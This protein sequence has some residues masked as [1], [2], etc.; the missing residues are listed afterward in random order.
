MQDRDFLCRAARRSWPRAQTSAMRGA[1]RLSI[2]SDTA[3]QGPDPTVGG[4]SSFPDSYSFL[5]LFPCPVPSS[6]PVMLDIL[7]LTP[8]PE[9]LDLSSFSICGLTW[10]LMSCC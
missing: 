9:P 10:C 1:A 2:C 8:A 6:L 5:L 7:S 3:L 4:S